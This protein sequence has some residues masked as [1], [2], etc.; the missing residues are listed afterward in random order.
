MKIDLPLIKGRGAQ[1][2]TANPYHNLVY[3][4]NPIDW[5]QQDENDISLKTQFIPTHPKTIL[6]K[7]TSPDIPADWSINPYQGCEHGC[8]YCYARNTHPYWGYS[9]GLEFEQKILV[10]QG[11]ASLLEKKLKHPKWKASHVMFSG[12]TDCYQPIERKLKITRSLLEIFWKY[13]HPVGMITKNSLILRDLDILKDMAAHNLVHVAISVTTLDD[14]VRK[15]LEPRTASIKSRL[16]TIK[17]LVNNNIPTMVMMA[18]IIPGLNEHEIFEL[19]KTV[20]DLGAH[21]VGY[22]M[23]RLNGD[24]AQIFTDWI[25]KAMPDRADKILNKIKDVHGGRLNDNR[26]GKR[27]SGEGHISEIIAK[28]F[29]LARKKYLGDRKSRPYNLDL[30]EDFK[31]PQLKL[32]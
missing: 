15:V 7:V 21:S 25:E 8:I 30:H 12:N 24:V 28:Q 5:E 22:T 17:T 10:K 13:R 32:F 9:A 16:N 20:A 2:N 19:V 18:P 27:M 11:A 31:N 23:V 6:N 1:I 14:E 26:F 3:D 29:K 4:E